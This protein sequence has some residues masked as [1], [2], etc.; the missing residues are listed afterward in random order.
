MRTAMLLNYALSNKPINANS[1]PIVKLAGP[2][3]YQ[4]S[5]HETDMV[6]NSRMNSG[7]VVGLFTR[8]ALDKVSSNVYFYLVS[9]GSRKS[10]L[11]HCC[12]AELERVLVNIVVII[13]KRDDLMF[14]RVRSPSARP[15]CLVRAFNHQVLCPI[16]K[17]GCHAGFTALKQLWAPEMGMRD[18]CQ[19]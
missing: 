19:H 13:N 17:C 2:Q 8:G 14:A 4:G 7:V 11:F 10:C 12:Q 3:I 6:H 18:D 1:E 9:A 5:T 15:S 16:R